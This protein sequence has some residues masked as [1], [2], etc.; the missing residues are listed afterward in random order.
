MSTTDKNEVVK[1]TSGEV[2]ILACPVYT[3][4]A[5]P[6]SVSNGMTSQLSERGKANKKPRIFDELGMNESATSKPELRAEPDRL[7][8]TQ[9]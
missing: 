2:T 1:W 5:R 4:Q 7:L 6:V 8:D 3:R 9:N